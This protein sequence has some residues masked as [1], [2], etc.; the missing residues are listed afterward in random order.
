MIRPA[1][2]GD[3]ATVLQLIRDLADYERASGQVRTTEDQLRE[4]LFGP[5]PSVYAHI[6][7]HDDDGRREIA[8]F[9]LWYL[10]FSTWTGTHGIHLE[11][12]YIRPERRSHGYGTGLLAEL[13]R[14]CFER[15]FE[16]FEWSVLYWNDSSIGFYRSLGAVPQDDHT[17]YRLGGEALRR[18]GSLHQ[19]AQP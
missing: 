10:S 13:A 12:L 5:S 3:V 11:D 17:T 6:A 7:E 1:R 16:R 8:G 14:I 9:A 19:R 18:L 2:P 4:A 15:G